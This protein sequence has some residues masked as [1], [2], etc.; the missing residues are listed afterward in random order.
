MR[1]RTFGVALLVGGGLALGMTLGPVVAAQANPPVDRLGP[2]GTATISATSIPVG[3][4]VL[5]GGRGFA[6]GGIVTVR[7]N[8]N[9]AG[10]V[11][12]DDQGNFSLQLPSFTAPGIYALT[13]SGPRLV[14][15]TAPGS[16][17]GAGSIGTALPAGAQDAAA[18]SDKVAQRT[19]AATV[20]VTDPSTDGDRSGTG[21]GIAV[22]GWSGDGGASAG[23]TGE[24]GAGGGIGVGF[25]ISGI[26]GAGGDGDTG[27]GGVGG[28]GGDTGGGGVGGGGGDTGGG[29]G[30]GTGGGGGSLVG[31]PVTGVQPGGGNDPG[32]VDQ[33]GPQKADQEYPE[34]GGLPF[35]GAE[36]GAMAAIAVALVG[37]GVILR[38]AARRRRSGAT[39]EEL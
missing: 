11:T 18:V 20:T 2:V 5:L 13:G 33:E 24:G 14:P 39:P 31:Q 35:T 16:A 27:G 36:T 1:F 30:G 22:G 37:G 9:T 38:V 32:G 12:A 19:V 21:V 34:A 26:N 4:S 6:P 17:A 8:G 7:V 10:T 25:G 29:G 23:A 15:V 28:G 3:Q